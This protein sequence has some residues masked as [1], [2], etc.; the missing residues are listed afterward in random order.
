MTEGKLAGF[1]VACACAHARKNMCFTAAMSD[2]R[3]TL[4]SFFRCTRRRRRYR[5]SVSIAFLPVLMKTVDLGPRAPSLPMDESA[6]DF[7]VMSHRCV[8]KQGLTEQ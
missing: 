6:S 3:A 7:E 4:S 5:S 8:E 2:R 1:D